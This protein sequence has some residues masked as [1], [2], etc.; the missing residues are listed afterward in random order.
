MESALAYQGSGRADA[1]ANIGVAVIG[2][3]PYGLS[4]AAHLRDRDV[5]FR[6]FG[7]PL[8]NWRKHMP[9]EMT[10]K[11]RPFASN[12]SDPRGAG[13]LA[14]YCEDHEIACDG[15]YTPLTL[16][17]FVSYGL[18]FQRR[19]VPDTDDRQVSSLR[20]AGYGFELVVEGGEVLRADR[21]VV[22]TG[23]TYFADLP[24]ELR[25]LPAGSAS[26]SF[27]HCD[28]SEFEGQDVTVL[29]GGAS[30]V[31]IAIH[32][33][34]A[35]ARTSLM[36][37]GQSVRFYPV[38]SEGSRTL[39]QR[40]THPRAKLGDSLALWFYEKRP[41]L[42]RYLPGSR[43]VEL[44]R[45]LLGPASP[46]TL[47]ERFESGVRVMTGKT[48]VGADHEHGRVR[49]TVRGEDGTVSE[50]ITDHVIA[51]TGYRPQ[52]S[53]MTFLSAE[54]RSAVKTLAGMPVLS[55]HF[56]SS[57]PGLYFVGL[58]AAGSFGPLMRFVAG[59]QYAASRLVKE[60]ARRTSRGSRSAISQ[61]TAAERQDLASVW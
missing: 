13:S 37:R 18:A 26:H 5:P 15:I 61:P 36:V 39:R 16:K 30:A 25:T 51:A 9:A 28:L 29:G 33:H 60:L 32:L 56:E 22:A 54:L 21:V 4:V 27:S 31:D 53:S 12:L 59:V 49:L 11:S 57:V 48:V 45:R 40:I 47:Q 46:E 6:I 10:L 14:K 42:F 34:E 3:G 20:R 35:G 8:E 19:F 38:D 1:V 44:V 55:S 7:R 17:L 23:I 24:D 58:A 52:I 50:W 41:S 2:A 43:R